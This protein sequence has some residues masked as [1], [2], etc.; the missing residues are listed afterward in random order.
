MKVFTA[1]AL[2]LASCAAML[3]QQPGD[4]APLKVGDTAPNF[5]LSS[6]MGGKVALADFKGKA[7]VVLAFFPAAFTGG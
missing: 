4:P 1:T 2:A 3:A 7:P 5:T 6:T